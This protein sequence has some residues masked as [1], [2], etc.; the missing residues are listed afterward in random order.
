MGLMLVLIFVL[1]VCGVVI[2]IDSGKLFVVVLVEIFVNE[3][4][5]IVGVFFVMIMYMKGEL[6]FNE[7]L[8]KIV[9]F[10]VKFLD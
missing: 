5:Q 7:K 1:M 10:D 6:I 9:V 2:G 8:N 4:V 3:E